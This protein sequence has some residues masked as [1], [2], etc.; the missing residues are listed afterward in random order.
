MQ[1][2]IAT[3]RSRDERIFFEHWEASFALFEFDFGQAVDDFLGLQADGH[4]A[5]EKI[6]DVLWVIVFP[7]PVIGVIGDAAGFVCLDLVAVHDPFDRA[8]AVDDV[9]VDCIGNICNTDVLVI[10]E[11]GFVFF[12]FELHLFDDEITTVSA[13]DDD[14]VRGGLVFVMQMNICQRPAGLFNLPELFGFVDEEDTG[15]GLFQIGCEFL[16]VRRQMEK[17]VDVEENVFLRDFGT[18]QFTGL[19]Q[20]KICDTVATNLFFLSGISKKIVHHFGALFIVV[21]RKTLSLFYHVQ[22]WNF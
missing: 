10:D 1:L 3:N 19:A 12:R 18:I 16:S 4:D 6:Q 22:T 13:F 14:A 11:D 15:Q 8:A 9:I 20:G 7:A 17:T 5:E 21:K 2:N